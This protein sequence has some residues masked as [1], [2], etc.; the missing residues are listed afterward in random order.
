MNNKRTCLYDKHVALGALISPFGGFDMPIQYSNITDEHQAVRQH[1]GVFDVSHMGEV[2]VSGTDAERYVNHI[3]TN[4]VEG[5]AVGKILYGM[6]CYEDGGV[7][8]D[9]LVYKMA[10][11]RFFLVINAANIDKDWAWIQLQAEG[12]NVILDNQ[13]DYYGQLA[14]QGPEAERI[15]EEILNLPCSELTF[16]TFKTMGDVIVSR[17]GYTGEDGFEI[18]ATPDYI[19]QCW[20]KLMAAGVTPCG[21][22]CRDTLRFEVGL[23]LYGDE[24]SA[25]ITP[26]MAGLGMFVKLDKEEFVGRDALAKQKAEGVAQKLVGIE[27][28]DKAIPRHGYTVMKDGQPI[29]TVTT[30]YHTISTD[31]SVCMALIDSQYA[32]L[33]TELEVQIRKKVFPGTVVKKRFY[34]KHYKK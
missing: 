25:E 19:N 32:P 2:L 1:C 18:Y 8:D 13:S 9:L 22:G 27:L 14:V 17:T 6:M 20:D 5:L 24:L 4:N 29:G 23:P 7:V 30:G 31:K 28:Q 15:M 12:F 21:L 3:F 16:Y 11:D 34:D 26:I 33:G 10:D